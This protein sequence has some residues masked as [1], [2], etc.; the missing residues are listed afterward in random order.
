MSRTVRAERTVHP[1]FKA[2]RALELVKPA[3]DE[4]FPC[5][6]CGRPAWWDESVQRYRHITVTAR[7][8]GCFL[9][10]PEIKA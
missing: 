3:K 1:D 4:I 9:I 5:N 10:S 2:R 7:A 6:D 8:R